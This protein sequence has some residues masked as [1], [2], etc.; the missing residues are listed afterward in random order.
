MGDSGLWM[1]LAAG[2]VVAVSGV[3][4]GVLV[5]R[6]RKQS[7][8]PE[9]S[10]TVIWKDLKV[11]YESAAVFG[12]LVIFLGLAAMGFAAVRLS[13]AP[14]SAHTAPLLPPGGQSP[15]GVGTTSTSNGT[16]TSTPA[17]RAIVKSCGLE[18]LRITQR[19]SLRLARPAFH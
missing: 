11:T 18:F 9:E 8:G 4:I 7:G 6:H 16:M 12:F 15:S 13:L 3:V 17:M 1:V 19:P 2:G 5:Y 10:L 14:S